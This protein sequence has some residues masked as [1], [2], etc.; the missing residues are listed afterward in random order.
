MTLK[1]AQNGLTHYVVAHLFPIR[2]HKRLIGMSNSLRFAWRCC[3]VD[4]LASMM[5]VIGMFTGLWRLD[6]LLNLIIV[7]AARPPDTI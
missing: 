1:F 4:R 7:F 6:E 5:E 2:A 3:L